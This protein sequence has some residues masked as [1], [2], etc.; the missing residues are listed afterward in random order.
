MVSDASSNLI[1]WSDS[2]TSFIV[3]RHEDFAREVLPRFFKHNNFASFVRQLNMYGFHKVPHIQ[4]G[5]L[6]AD[7]DEAEQWEFS[8]PNFRRDQPDLLCLVQRKKGRE[9]LTLDSQSAVSLG[10]DGTADAT[11][12]SAGSNSLRTSSGHVQGNSNA[13]ARSLDLHQIIQEL[14]AVKKHQLAISEEL[15]EIQRENRELWAEAMAART[16]HERQQ[17]TIDKIMSFLASVF[18]SKR[19]RNIHARNGARRRLL[20]GDRNTLY[21]ETEGD[22]DSEVF[23]DIPADAEAT[24]MLEE[25]NRQRDRKDTPSDTEKTTFQDATMSDAL[26]SASVGETNKMVGSPLSSA[27][28]QPSTTTT[29][30]EA[31]AS[32]L[33][34]GR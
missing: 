28:Q 10:P 22:S 21:S 30:T 6:M 31:N 34:T 9:N 19:A 26:S 17:E 27:A 23:A 32:T 2:G 29:N 15:K 3:T 25:I 11:K 1:R 16:R 13:N 5:V 33:V 7:S 18:A 12:V 24:A 8:N 20:L 14:A 4:Q